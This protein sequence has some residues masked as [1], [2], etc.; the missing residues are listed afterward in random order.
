MYHLVRFIPRA[1]VNVIVTPSD[2]DV[3][4]SFLK[5]LAVDEGILSIWLATI[6]PSHH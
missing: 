4:A 1:I 6:P 5:Q 2:F 3:N